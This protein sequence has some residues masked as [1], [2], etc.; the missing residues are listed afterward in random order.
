MIILGNNKIEK[1]PT[2]FLIKAS[3]D[4]LKLE[5]NWLGNVFDIPETYKGIILTK[6][7]IKNVWKTCQKYQISIDSNTME[8]NGQ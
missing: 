3:C 4:A 8:V 1:D 7:W 6:S 2:G 5:A